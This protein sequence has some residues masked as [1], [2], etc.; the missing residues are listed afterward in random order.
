MN[1]NI[2]GFGIMARQI[3]A[4]LVSMGNNITIWNHK[5]IDIDKLYK[6][7]KI[8]AKYLGTESND[9]GKIKVITSLA[10]LEDN[11]TIEAIT[12]NLT[13]KKDLYN[14][15]KLKISH[16]YFTISSSISPLEIGENVNGLHFF[17]PIVSC[18]II[19][20]FNHSIKNQESF[21]LLKNLEALGFETINVLNTRGYIANYILFNE[22]SNIFKLIEIYNYPLAEIEKLYNL[23]FNKNIFKTI[24]IVGVDVTYAII[25]NLKEKDDSIYLPKILEKAIEKGVLGKKNLTSIK[26]YYDESV[27]V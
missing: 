15:L 21:E 16:D 12:E 13:L 22:I 11:L 6:Q 4:L 8:Q 20:F 10:E 1:I 5:E 24:D 23:L 18:K 17:N 19:E 25:K 3:S 14:R 26:K 9:S 2:L 27:K 7:I